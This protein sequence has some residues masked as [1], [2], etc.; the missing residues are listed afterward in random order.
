MMKRFYSFFAAVILLLSANSVKAHDYINETVQEG[1]KYY[2][3]NV[4][5]NKFLNDNNGLDEV[6]TT[7]WTITTGKNGSLQSVGGKYVKMTAKGGFMG[8]GTTYTWTTNETSAATIS[9]VRQDDG[10]Y[11]I[12]GASLTSYLAA[13]NNGI[14]NVGATAITS[15]DFKWVAVSEVQYQRVT[16]PTAS[17]KGMKT[18]AVANGQ[19]YIANAITGQYLSTGENALGDAPALWT[20][21]ANEDGLYTMVSGK[22][23][24]NVTPKVQ[25]SLGGLVEADAFTTA[26]TASPFTVAGEDNLYTI[27]YY[28]VGNLGT[29]K[30]FYLAV[31]K[32]L[33]FEDNEPLLATDDE[34]GVYGKWVFVSKADYD[35][36]YKDKNVA[37]DRL[38]KAIAAAEAVGDYPIPNVM[39]LDYTA[40]MTTAK[41]LIGVYWMPTTTV[42]SINN[43][44]AGLEE[45]VGKI[46]DVSDVYVACKDAA[47][48]I[49]A[50]PG[51]GAAI[52]GFLGD[53]VGLEIATTKEAMIQSVQAM[54]TAALVNVLLPTTVFKAGNDLTG[55][56]QNHSFDTGDATG[57]RALNGD[58][59]SASTAVLTDEN[60][61]NGVGKYHFETNTFSL[62]GAGTG[63]RIIQPVIGLKKGDY[64]LKVKA[65]SLSTLS[66]KIHL[67]A[68]VIPTDL[69]DITHLNDPTALIGD[70]LKNITNIISRGI[71]KEAS[72]DCPDR[73]NLEEVELQF[74]LD[75][76]DPILIAMNCGLTSVTGFNAFAADEV[77][78]T[79]L[80][81]GVITDINTVNAAQGNDTYYNIG[82]SAVAAPAKGIN[83]QRT[84]DGKV[85]KFIV[86]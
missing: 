64:S 25:V 6:P 26:E 67:N 50:I 28:H 55:L 15:D 31:A 85:K 53:K 9:E 2:L 44:A 59:S 43:S 42:S 78:L 77:T 1:V 62:F 61:T 48:H 83:I 23:N 70:I 37:V 5:A 52:S 35:N 8:I 79:Y 84:A 73:N 3:Y 36:F 80:G 27:S 30:T 38:R 7:L 72:K 39:K 76:A 13:D 18:S 60:M 46:K 68:I 14:K 4:G 74:T 58:L 12:I 40:K 29:K 47:D 49:Q 75:A 54:R 82:G 10:Y 20:V 16:N 69:I 86:K 81:E 71:I 11:T 34:P 24:L 65:A 57:W 33:E 45:L 21:K 41:Y 56:I 66:N 19:F 51:V 63:E 22:N 32:K 17:L